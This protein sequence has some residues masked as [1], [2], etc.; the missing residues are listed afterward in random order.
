MQGRNQDIDEMVREPYACIS[1]P[2]VGDAT[3][4]GFAYCIILARDGPRTVVEGV[5]RTHAAIF[6]VEGYFAAD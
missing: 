2:P 3:G 4:R 6:D 1:G 5:G